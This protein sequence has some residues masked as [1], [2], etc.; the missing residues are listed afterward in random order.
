MSLLDRALLSNNKNKILELADAQKIFGYFDKSNL[1]KL[2]QSIFDADQQKSLN[3][4]KQIYDQGIEP[5]VFLNDFI[6]LLYY[7]KNI[8]YL[9][10]EMT[11]FDLNDEQ[12]ELIKNLRHKLDNQTLILF[13]QFAIK[14]LQELDIVS[15]QNI[16]I[17]MFL[18]RLLYIRS[19]KNNSSIINKITQTEDNTISTKKD[20]I[21]N[22][23]INQIRNITQE[24][25]INKPKIKNNDVKEIDIKNLNDLIKL[26]HLKKEAKL[27]Y[28][29]ETNVNLVSF[30]YG[31]IEI[32]FNERLD[33]DF[34][35][36][37]TSKLLDWTN[38]RW[39]ISL[40]KEKGS[41][42]FKDVKIE[43]K[44]NLIESAKKT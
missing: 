18:I 1:I 20:F 33:K 14:T 32:S 40:T 9:S 16:S 23:A 12:F 38:I 6:E 34:I 39:L 27:K 7:F 2:F 26:C 10:S 25:S 11:S 21:N 31:R 35:K 30:D 15:D 41:K 24:K 29:L 4:Y 43:S 44:K 3:I 37:L 28:E 13:W 8:D 36:L 17:E 22:D 19:L 42:S 5:K